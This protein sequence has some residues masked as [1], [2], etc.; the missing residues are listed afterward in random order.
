VAEALRQPGGAPH[1]KGATAVEV[2]AGEDPVEIG[3][4]AADQ[5]RRAVDRRG[6]RLREGGAALVACVASYDVAA[7]TLMS[8]PDALQASEAW[9]DRTVAWAQGRW[10]DQRHS[11]IEHRD[12]PQ[13]H[14]HILIVPTLDEDRRLLVGAIHPRI[15]ARDERQRAGASTTAQTLAYLTAI[16]RLLDEFHTVVGVASGLSCKSAVPRQR[17]TREQALVGRRQRECEIQLKETERRQI[18]ASDHLRRQQETTDA[19]LSDLS[20]RENA[21]TATA[22]DHQRQRR[23]LAVKRTNIEAASAKNAQEHARL[24]G[25][26]RTTM[27]VEAAKLADENLRLRVKLEAARALT[28]SLLAE[29]DS[30]EPA[31]AASGFAA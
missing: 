17:L 24:L 13:W 9:R 5:A 4:R 1:V 18:V 11:V 3:G 29:R 21:L 23:E 25:V 2:I 14:L 8:D 7:V 22:V 30:D 6:H 20:Q 26:R 28:A 27:A 12:E 15:S 16:S 31:S 10:G 19:R